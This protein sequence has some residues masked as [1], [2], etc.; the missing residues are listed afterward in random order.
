M[1]IISCLKYF[2]S[3]INSV[4]IFAVLN[5]WITNSYGDEEICQEVSREVI[6]AEKKFYSTKAT[7]TMG[8]IISTSKLD[9][10]LSDSSEL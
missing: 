4:F 2:N 9:Y 10:S 5:L 6:D 1:K 8:S 7:F 3:L